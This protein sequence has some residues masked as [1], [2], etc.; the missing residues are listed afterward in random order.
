VVLKVIFL[1]VCT[2]KITLF[3]QFFTIYDEF[4]GLTFFDLVTLGLLKKKQWIA[5]IYF[6][7]YWFFSF[8]TLSFLYRP[9]IYNF[10]DHK[11]GRRIS[12]LLIPFYLFVL[13]SISFYHQKSNYFTLQN[14]SDEIIANHNNYEDLKKESSFTNID[15]TIQSKVIT[16]SF[17]KI[18][19]S[20]HETIENRIYKF[21][22]ELK[23]EKD[24]RGLHSSFRAG[25]NS[26]TKE[27]SNLINKKDSLR[28]AYIATFNH[29]Y[30]IKIDST[31]Y[32]SEFIIDKIDREKFGFETYIGINHLTEGKHLITISRFIKKDSV[33]KKVVSRIPFWYFKN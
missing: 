24:N 3:T 30:S 6:P 21:N 1:L 27:L 9:L 32:K 23:P 10:L 15:F 20:F 18:Y 5:K 8:L 19:L 7:F 14:D 29:I 22:S 11:F 2:I 13:I 12:A 16:S 4:F 25:Y 33:G 17:V 28:R 31:N 26:K